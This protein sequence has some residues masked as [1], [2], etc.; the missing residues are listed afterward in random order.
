MIINIKR[1]NNFLCCSK[2]DFNI[3]F[4]HSPVFI[5]IK[6]KCEFLGLVTGAYNEDSVDI[7]VSHNTAK[8]ILKTFPDTQKLKLTKF[9]HNN[10][11]IPYFTIF[12]VEQVEEKEDT[13]NV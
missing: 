8:E 7:S 13:L 5:K 4:E 12:L 11:Q 9:A 6:D 3:K 2:E 1:A 10:Q